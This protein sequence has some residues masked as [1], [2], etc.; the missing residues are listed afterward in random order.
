MKIIITGAN[1]FVG[2]ALCRY[3]YH[4]GHQ[5][6]ATGRQAEPNAGL[7][8]YATYF[9]ADITQPMAEFD[10]DVC[11]HA[12]ALTSDTA[13][14]DALF[15][16]N[17]TG[18]ENVLKAAKNCRMFVFISSS[19]VYSFNEQSK[20]E[21]DADPEYDI[22]DYGKTKLLAEAL[23]KK[24]I[25]GMQRRLIL[26]PRGI[27]GV[28]DRVLLPNILKL[29]KGGTILNPIDGQVLTSATHVKNLGYA[30]NLF[31][32]QADKPPLQLFNVADAE[33]Y[34]LKDITLKMLDAVEG[35]KLKV[36]PIPHF[37]MRLRGGLTPIAKKTLKT[38]TVIEL[39][40]IKKTLSYDA[41]Y[42]FDNSH[43]EIGEWIR[44]IGGK[45]FYLDNLKDAPWILN[46]FE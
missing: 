24:H 7:L 25:P 15:L 37:A 26:R 16:N 41:P 2:A 42:T 27:Y 5:V 22:S 31:F 32:E 21:T 1:G 6:I 13:R 39:W 40:E 17:V 38:N 33:V 9:Q 44:K 34:H 36:F 10:A 30:I 8:K 45:K 18:T 19:S 35:H 3:F 28:G 29:L 11:I 43:A 12:A 14:Y 4:Q 20:I 46:G 23:V